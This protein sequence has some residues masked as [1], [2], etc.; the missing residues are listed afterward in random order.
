MKKCPF[1]AEEIQDEAIFCKHCR[2]YLSDEAK[3]ALMHQ[4]SST[5]TPPQVVREFQPLIGA[6]RSNSPVKTLMVVFTI[7]IFIAFISMLE[8]IGYGLRYRDEDFYAVLLFLILS[9]SFIGFLW[10]TIHLFCYKVSLYSEC[11]TIKTLIRTTTIAFKQ[12]DR[13]MIYESTNG[14]SSKKFYTIK[15]SYKDEHGKPLSISIK[16]YVKD[17]LELYQKGSSIHANLH[18]PVCPYCKSNRI[19]SFDKV[20]PDCL[21]EIDYNE[22]IK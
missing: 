20:C 15:I 7:L 13:F 4:S 8:Y 16:Y 5:G 11:I 12:I 14:R 9:G 1:C 17:I 3:A 21:K 10:F 19:T 22:L 2:N 18:A 6:Y